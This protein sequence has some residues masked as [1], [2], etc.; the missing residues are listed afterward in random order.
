MLGYTQEK[1]FHTERTVGARLADPWNPRLLMAKPEDIERYGEKI[2][3]SG[4]HCGDCHS[5][6]CQEGSGSLALLK[7][8]GFAFGQCPLRN[9][10]PQV[11]VKAGTGDFEGA[12][13]TITASNDIGDIT[14]AGCPADKLCQGGCMLFQAGHASDHIAVT[15]RSV[16]EWGW[17]KGL[18]KPIEHLYD[19]FSNAAST[20]VEGKEKLQVSMIG[21]GVAVHEPMKMMLEHGADVTAYDAKDVAGGITHWSIPTTKLTR[22][23]Y[24]RYTE[25]F[26][27][28]GA[29]YV[30][31]TR[32][33]QTTSDSHCT[34]DH[35]AF[36]ELAE[37]SDVVFIGTGLQSFNWL[38]ENQLSR[39]KQAQFIQGIDFLE[40]QNQHLDGRGNAREYQGYN[41]EGQ[42]I[43]VV[44]K[45]D[46]AWD[47]VATA[48][49]QRAEKV[50]VLVR[51]STL[52]GPNGK[53]LTQEELD[54][55]L[56]G[57]IDH[58]HLRHFK[59]DKEIRSAIEEAAHIARH[60]KV[61]VRDILDIRLN[62]NIIDNDITPGQQRLTITTADAEV[63]DVLDVN[64]V[65]LAMGSNGH[66]L[67][68][69]F[70]F[71]SDDF[72]MKR[73]GRLPVTPYYSP[74]AR[75]AQLGRGSGH[76]GGLVGIYKTESGRKVPV[77]A[78]G[79]VTRDSKGLDWR[80]ESALIVNAY[81]DGVNVMPDVFEA[82]SKGTRDR[83]VRW[84]E[85]QPHL[86]LNY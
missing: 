43:A 53:Q 54:A 60:T 21:T 48:F 63:N 7:G 41:T 71:T 62:A 14:G 68:T 67:K 5:S 16:V 47:V 1:E 78:V 13:Q 20:T 55:F 66:D 56:E 79:D 65:V 57:A 30:L 26:E 81:R 50:T 85:H 6:T 73:G 31:S 4:A 75:V 17:L 51:A 25:R 77:F 83:F 86:R 64:K 28:G 15:E 74:E 27:E 61:S 72:Q 19:T 59:M 33:G 37:K 40:V 10:I 29:K 18:I 42:S 35:I 80:D 39:E 23:A 8:E 69:E 34:T 22:E 2:E 38:P 58:K 84:A 45:G 11:Q 46:T 82:S 3:K 12:L 32:V 52:E 24:R 9:R 44:G 76:G 70:G 36:E 49:R